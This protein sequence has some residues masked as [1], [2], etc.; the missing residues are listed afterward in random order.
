M[1]GSPLEKGAED[2]RFRGE[3]KPALRD[4]PVTRAYP[5]GIGLGDKLGCRGFRAC[6]QRPGT[7][8]V[9]GMKLISWNVNGVR[10]TL[11]KGLLDF[12]KAEDADIVCLQ[13]TKARPDDVKEEWPGYEAHWNWA[14]KRATAAYSR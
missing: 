4:K 14:E 12:L 13:E 9:A 11:K 3:H 10:A 8:V 6:V 7:A 1:A 5:I 2:A